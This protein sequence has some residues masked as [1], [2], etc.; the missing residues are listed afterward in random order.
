[1]PR[2]VRNF[3]AEMEASGY[4]RSAKM[5][6]RNK[7]GCLDI[8]VYARRNKQPELALRIECVPYGDA[9]VVFVQGEEVWRGKR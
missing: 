2:N 4:K 6:P 5:G 8:W 1:M 3:W 9:N 7:E